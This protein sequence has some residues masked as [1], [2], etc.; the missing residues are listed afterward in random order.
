MRDHE[1]TL[2]DPVCGMRVE[3]DQLA[4]EYM[5]MHFAF[6]SNNAAS[7]SWQTRACMSANLA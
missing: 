1:R 6:C 7:G 3:E 4:L 2:I 5:Q